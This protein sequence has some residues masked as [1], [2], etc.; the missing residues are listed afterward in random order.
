MK[1]LVL[2]GG[3]SKGAFVG[4]ML[5]YLSNYKDWDLFAG[6]ST[7]SLL[8]LLVSIKDFDSLKKDILIHN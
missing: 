8:Q 3:G 7:G 2:S 1:A 4:G 6:T 5:E